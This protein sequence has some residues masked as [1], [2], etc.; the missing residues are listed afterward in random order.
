[1]KTII[2]MLCI[3]FIILSFNNISIAQ[4]EDHYH[5][6]SGKIYIPI[7]VDH[8]EVWEHKN[9]NIKEIHI[10][11]KQININFNMKAEDMRVNDNV[12][13][14]I[15]IKTSAVLDEVITYRGKVSEDKQVMEYFEITKDDI[16][17]LTGKREV[18]EKE[19]T[20]SARFEN[21][22]TWMG[23]Y[24]FKY[25]VTKIAS[26][27][28]NEKYT[29]PHYGRTE[30]Y[31][32]SF[33]KIN[34][35]KITEYTTNCV[36]VGFKPG[37]LKLEPVT[38][39]TVEGPDV[40]C[41]SVSFSRT[42]KNRPCTIKLI[43][44]SD[45]TAGT[46]KWEF[47]SEAILV[48]ETESNGSIIRIRATA[49]YLPSPDSVLVKV[50]QK[51]GAVEFSASHVLH[52]K[53]GWYYFWPDCSEL[54][55]LGAITEDEKL[56]CENDWFDCKDSL[57][58]E[59]YRGDKSGNKFDGCVN[60]TALEFQDL[61]L[62]EHL[63]GG[64]ELADPKTKLDSKKPNQVWKLWDENGDPYPEGELGQPREFLQ[65]M[66]CMEKWIKLGKTKK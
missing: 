47:D 65:E 25:G 45:V 53:G 24:R 5:W 21:I 26:V 49:D 40:I 11:D 66:P 29:I 64:S 16:L 35:D 20:L 13:S 44:K 22:P 23:S 37:V 59:G 63:T 17:Y 6:F 57:E 58:A 7:I 27:K 41:R 38:H 52:L 12:F 51:I 33:V 36:G 2:N 50:S 39:L 60:I 56:E 55:K 1:M 14:G 19:V 46:F 3:T 48:K 18:I 61:I 9:G 54:L 42:T 4:I 62:Q 10:P 43:A 34:E 8:Q 30:S 15:I 32:E 28:Y 31:T